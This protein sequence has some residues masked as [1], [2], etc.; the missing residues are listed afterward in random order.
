[1]EA[2]LPNDPLLSTGRRE[3]KGGGGGNG[4]VHVGGGMTFLFQGT[5]PGK[6]GGHTSYRGLPYSIS[7][8]VLREKKPLAKVLS[9]IFDFVSCL[10]SSTRFP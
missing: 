10:L 4:Q 7:V 2:K 6:F 1:M 5:N 9:R 3:C 8:L